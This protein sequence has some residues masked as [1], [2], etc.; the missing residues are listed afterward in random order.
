MLT[1]GSILVPTANLM[2]QIE[3]T[4]HSGVNLAAIRLP[5]IHPTTD[6]PST[7]G[8]AREPTIDFSPGP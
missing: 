6:S 7:N 5:F 2:L 3:P 8:H 1:P 4:T